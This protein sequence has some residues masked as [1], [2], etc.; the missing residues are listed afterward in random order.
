MRCY[1]DTPLARVKAASQ[2]PPSQPLFET[3]FV[4]E[5]YRLD[6]A[7]RALG[8]EWAKR[9]VEL[10]ELTNFPI[11]LAAYDG[12]ELAFKIEFD[13]QRLEDATVRRMLGHLRQLLQ[14]I[15]KNPSASVGAM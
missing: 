9:H 11:T 4:F 12:E 8:G 5:N 13:R 1:D 15:A 7:M 3:L 2:V 14:G 10:H 6:T